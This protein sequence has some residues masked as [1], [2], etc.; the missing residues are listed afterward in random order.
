M[1]YPEC[2][3]MSKVTEKS[4][5]IGEFL[6]WLSEEKKV[7]IGSYQE[8]ESPWDKEGCTRKEFAPFRY[9]TE[10]LLAEFFGI[11]LKKVEQEKRAML[12]EI[13]ANMY[14]EKV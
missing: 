11:D 9:D 12:A 14:G 7:V 3:K 13:R 2:E 4:Q 5:S 1:I 10:K 6:E 8:F